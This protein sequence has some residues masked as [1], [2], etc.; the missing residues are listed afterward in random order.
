MKVLKISVKVTGIPMLRFG[1]GGG[2]FVRFIHFVPKFVPKFVRSFVP[3]FVEG[4]M[5][6][7]KVSFDSRWLCG[8]FRV[9]G[10]VACGWVRLGSVR[11]VLWCG[12][13]M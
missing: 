1:G 11:L 5:D 9:R 13:V 8:S 12:D 3:K 6:W 7:S 4:W 10:C 2:V